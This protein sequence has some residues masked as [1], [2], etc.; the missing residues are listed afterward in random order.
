[1]NIESQPLPAQG[2]SCDFDPKSISA[3]AAN[4]RILELVA[5]VSQI[6]TIALRTALGR[7]T[8]EDVLSRVQVPN[9]TN[10]AMDGYALM[11]SELPDDDPVMFEVVG[12]SF[13]GK[14]FTK[15]IRPGHCV[16]IMTGAVMPEGS[17]TVVIQERVQRAGEQ[18]TVNPGE[19][20]GSNVRQAGEDLQVGDVAIARGT[21]IGPAHLGLAASLGFS[22]LPCYRK[23]R[24]AFFSNGD[25][26]RS[27]G[28]SLEV[29][30][31]YDSNRYTLFGMLTEA[32]VEL[33]DL[34]IV[35]DDQ[36][37]IAQAFSDASACADIVL[38]SAGASV[39]DAD[40]VKQTLDQMGAVSFW[41]V[42][43]KPGRPLAFGKVGESLFFG[44]P[45]NP[46]SVMVTFQIFVREAIRKLSGELNTASLKMKVP[47]TSTLKKRAGRV[48]YQ[49]GIL[50]TTPD[51]QT[52][53]SST[54]EQGS[55]I[56][57]SM[58]VAN[59][60]IILPADS[61][62]ASPGD[63]VEIQPFSQKL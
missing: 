2:P 62:G 20:P 15:Q 44:L 52:V 35:P 40:Y 8:A 41:K 26:L 30:E 21:R 18:I 45:G 16:R 28:Q 9:H 5:P 54:G 27:V 14:P 43:I 33:V 3:D 6:E 63:Q 38:T 11:G 4:K 49:R 60:F 22:E 25:E 36:N 29:G 24:V 7:V 13:A 42:A 32:G 57:H 59:C 50:T 61:E 55:G 48:E 31:L 47:L 10:S 1:M 37:A 58:S 19:K 17:D 46:V 51:G 56:L 34:G 39:G 53:V 23:P 12:T